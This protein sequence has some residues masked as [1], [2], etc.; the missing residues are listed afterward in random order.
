MRL[1]KRVL[2]CGFGLTVLF[3]PL[4]GARQ[5]DINSNLSAE[6]TLRYESARAHTDL[7]TAYLADGKLGIAL[8]ELSIA[9]QVYSNYAPA[10]YTLG[11]VHME[12]KENDLAEAAFKKAISI[13]PDSS[14]AYNNY[15]WFQCQR[16]R[17]E[18]GI[19]NFM[20]ALKN[21]RYETPEKAYVNAG[22]CSRKKDDDVAAMEYFERALKIRPAHPQALFNLAEMHFRKADF[23]S[24]KSFLLRYMKS[25]SPD[26][27]VLWLGV[28]VERKLDDR[29]AA[30]SYAQML[31]QRFPDARE[32]QLLKAER[33]E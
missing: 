32:T 25:N 21:P 9:T 18:E 11:L 8:E 19:K 6:D 10:F 24:A 23:A 26:A 30:A 12:L 29:L 22:I 17:V 15:G 28:R 14:E 27:E 13:D 4:V 5:S 7:G 16:G 20:T 31:R 2:V 3:S 33:Y 1:L